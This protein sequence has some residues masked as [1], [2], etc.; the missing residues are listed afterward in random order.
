[1]NRAAVSEQLDAGIPAAEIHAQLER[2]LASSWFVNSK[3]HTRFL[4]FIVEKAIAGETQDIKERLIGI[5]VFDRCPNYDLANDAIVRVGAGEI[6]KRLAQYYLHE[7]RSNEIVIEVP[8]GAYVP[9]FS[10]PQHAATAPNIAVE[11]RVDLTTSLGT[12]LSSNAASQSRPQTLLQNCELRNS[13][14]QEPPRSRSRQHLISLGI[15]MAFALAITVTVFI[16]SL[17]AEKDCIGLWKPFLI[18][19][20]PVLICVGDLESPTPL[21]TVPSTGKS[22]TD[23]IITSHHVGPSNLHAIGRVMS[24][25]DTTGKPVKT[26]M[27]DDI[28][29]TVL[30]SQPDILMGAFDNRW[31]QSILSNSRFR[32]R[33]D[34]ASGQDSIIDSGNPQQPAWTLNPHDPSAM[35]HRDFALV[36]RINSPLTGQ[37]ALIMAGLGP[38]G[39]TAASVFATDPMYF[40]QFTSKAP[41]GWKQ[42]NIE[43]VLSTEVVNGDSSPPHMIL[44]YV[45]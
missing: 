2:I 24:V 20:Q 16:L 29:L 10:R 18:H 42:K 31:T 27:A 25:L 45:W 44:F 43:I 30:Q 28:D 22:L 17:R 35:I 1:M 41:R 14:I 6:R 39:T 9:I 13:Q 32:F 26:G 5:E 37:P 11:N 36:A 4:R 23:L 8:P 12:G 7:G 15:G 40:R 38:Y 33:H 34:P 3:R 19:D 21:G